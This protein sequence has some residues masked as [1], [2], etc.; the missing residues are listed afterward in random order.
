MKF[1]KKILAV[2]LA[3][4]LVCA[5]FAGCS[6]AAN[7]DA[8]DANKEE[9]KTL[10]M[11]TNAEFPPY[12]YFEND[13]VI[14]IDAEIAQAI[15]DK[16]GYELKIEHIEFDSI[17]PGVQGGK[18]DFGMA[19]MTV[20][21][22]RQKQVSFTQSYA[23]GVQSIIVKEGSDIKTA[24]DLSKGG[25]KIGVQ[26]ATTGDLYCTW[27]I[28]DEGLGTV[29]RYAK[30]AD[31]VMALTSDKVDAVVIDNNPAKV[32]VEQNDGLVL[33]D[34]AYAEEDYA[35][36]VNKDNKE[37]LDAMDKALE[38]LIADGTVQQILDKYIKA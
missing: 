26:K 4:V 19:G 23:K 34:T 10:I 5:C 17:I 13:K 15:C 37:L 6:K 24:D 33:L 11:A 35:I 16:L 14:G 7:D 30:G 25:L 29:D 36:A 32:F 1:T 27:D 2:L 31:A 20:T 3:A 21:E 38:E 28:E 18:Y 12:E 9:K 8:A 22:E